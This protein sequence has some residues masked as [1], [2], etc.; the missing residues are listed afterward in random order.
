MVEWDM[1]RSKPSPAQQVTTGRFELEQDGQVAFLEYSL[2]GDVL[3]LTHT[4]VPESLRGKGL[5][6]SLAQ[7]ALVWAR[8]H[9]LKVD[10]VCSTVKKYVSEHPE[11]ADLVLH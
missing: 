10:I 2:S 3:E 9:N 6:F 5:A 8:D 1:F 11:Y 4:E 7:T